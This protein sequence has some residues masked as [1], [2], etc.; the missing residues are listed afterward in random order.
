MYRFARRSADRKFVALYAVVCVIRGSENDNCYQD[1]P[2]NFS[3]FQPC[4]AAA[5][6]D[7]YAQG[8]GV[9]LNNAVL[10]IA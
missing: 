4:K 6:S 9:I 3:A 7:N 8:L 2:K 10:V 5:V 1:Y